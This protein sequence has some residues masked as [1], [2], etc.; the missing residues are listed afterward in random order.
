MV[1]F[2]SL[3]NLTRRYVSHVLEMFQCGKHAGMKFDWSACQVAMRHSGKQLDLVGSLSHPCR[4]GNIL[5]SPSVM[6]KATH[7]VSEAMKSAA[8]LAE[9]LNARVGQLHG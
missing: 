4:H 2:R 5:C 6:S 7:H 9:Q 3:A 8:T 1:I